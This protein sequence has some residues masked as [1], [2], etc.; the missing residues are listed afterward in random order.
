[1]TTEI[2]LPK[3]YPF[4]VYCIR[5]HFW[6]LFCAFGAA[7]CF[8]SGYWQA[9]LFIALIARQCGHYAAEWIS[10]K[11]LLKSVREFEDYKVAAAERMERMKEMCERHNLPPP[12]Q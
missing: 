12:G 1:M 4:Q 7:S 6:T 9:W 5:I 11:D 2:K 10:Y 8:Y 3:V